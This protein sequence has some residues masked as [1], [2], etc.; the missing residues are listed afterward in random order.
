MWNCAIDYPPWQRNGRANSIVCNKALRH[1]LTTCRMHSVVTKR[2]NLRARVLNRFNDNRT[3]D[4]NSRNDK[5]YHRSLSHELKKL[6]SA[7]S[8]T[9]TER[10]YLIRIKRH[11]HGWRFVE[12]YWKR[13]RFTATVDRRITTIRL[14][15]N[16]GCDGHWKVETKSESFV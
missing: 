14:H 6:W 3:R 13:G 7:N 9:W 5:Q 1:L 10:E 2:S 8:S 16:S 11:E 15:I 12:K 4:W